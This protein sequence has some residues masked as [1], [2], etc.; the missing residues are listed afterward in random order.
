VV[1]VTV[2]AADFAALV[3]E[4]VALE[5]EL[6]ELRVASCGARI[7]AGSQNAY[8]RDRITSATAGGGQEW[9]TRDPPRKPPTALAQRGAGRVL[10]RGSVVGGTPTRCPAAARLPSQVGDCPVAAGRRT[11]S[12]GSAPTRVTTNSSALGARRPAYG[13]GVPPPR[14]WRRAP[15]GTT[16]SVDVGPR[17]RTSKMTLQRVGYPN[18]IGGA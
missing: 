2:S 5:G 12:S 8:P 14:P 15:C 18:G 10:L 3:V 4:L 6:T 13:R 1:A 16:N 17:R 11:S 7:P 9:P